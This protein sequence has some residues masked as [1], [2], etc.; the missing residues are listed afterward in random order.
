[1][2]PAAFDYYRPTSL[3]EALA[4]FAE[5]GADAK[6]LAGGQSLV[7]AMNFRLARPGVLVDLNALGSLGTI[8]ETADGGIR[9]G[10]MARQTAVERNPAVARRAPLLAEAMPWI[11][12]P[13]IRNRGT[14]GGSLA[15]ADPSAELPAVMLALDARF[16]ARSSSGART[17]PASEFFTGILST[18]LEPAELLTA[19]EIPVRPG[20]SGSA[21]V[22]VARRHGDYALVGVAAEVVL[23]REGACAAARIALL[24][25]GD[26]P[27]L[28]RSAMAVLLGRTPDAAAIEEAA[29]AAAE[30]DIE[31]PADIHASAAYRRHLSAVLVGRALRTAVARA[32]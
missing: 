16:V 5:L 2:K 6:A 1:M 18:A 26:T 19:I 24:S 30:R 3:D 21:F 29:R 13:Q 11:A 9:I 8:E 28:A 23:D 14:V 15:H 12:H 7:P 17:I 22:E 27:V 10:A 31:P 4:L 32:R 25:V 20:R